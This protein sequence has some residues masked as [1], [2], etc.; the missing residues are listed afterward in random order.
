MPGL[1]LL[2]CVQ[3]VFA[4]QWRFAYRYRTPNLTDIDHQGLHPDQSC[5]PLGTSSLPGAVPITDDALAGLGS[6]LAL[7]SCVLTAEGFLDQQLGINTVTTQEH[8]DLT[9]NLL[10]GNDEQVPDKTVYN[11][12]INS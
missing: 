9:K 11:Q 7:D 10:V 4:L 8:G 5:A 3:R 2:K 6:V 1:P 12:Q